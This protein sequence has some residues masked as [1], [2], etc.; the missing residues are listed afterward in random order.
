[1]NHQ[2]NRVGFVLSP[3]SDPLLNSANFYEALLNEA[4]ST[5]HPQPRNGS[6]L[7]QSSLKK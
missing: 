6:R 7:P 3:D 1:M 2:K 5:L 4:A